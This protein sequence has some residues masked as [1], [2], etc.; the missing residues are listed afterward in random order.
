MEEITYGEIPEEIAKANAVLIAAA[1]EL[2]AAL[3][4][5]QK[6]GMRKTGR[7]KVLNMVDAALAKAVQ[8]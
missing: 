5:V 8:P 4:E 1:P 7:N 3:V 2:Y 6:L